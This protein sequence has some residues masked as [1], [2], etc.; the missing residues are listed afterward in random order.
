MEQ[1]YH[2][3]NDWG[4]YI[5]EISIDFLGPLKTKKK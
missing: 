4:K 1:T 2:S 5:S 3:Q